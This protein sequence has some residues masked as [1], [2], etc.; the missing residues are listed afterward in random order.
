MKTTK[1]RQNLIR[2]MIIMQLLVQLECTRV[3]GA[4]RVIRVILVEVIRNI[5]IIR[6]FMLIS[7]VSVSELLWL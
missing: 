4:I 3:A 5:S 7:V 6:A 2:L 1:R